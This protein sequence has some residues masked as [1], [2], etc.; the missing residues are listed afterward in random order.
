MK[1]MEVTMFRE[2]LKNIPKDSLP[3]GFY[4]DFFQKGDEEDWIQVETAAGEFEN[5]EK[6]R[7]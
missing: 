3:K 7:A 5:K 4:L 6:A 1:S 2:N